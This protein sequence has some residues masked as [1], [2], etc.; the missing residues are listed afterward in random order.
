MFKLSL[1]TILM[2]SPA[3]AEKTP[4]MLDRIDRSRKEIHRVA[5]EQ[6]GDLNYIRMKIMAIDTDLK[7]LIKVT[8][9]IVG[10]CKSSKAIES[11]ESCYTRL[12]NADFTNVWKDAP[13][14]PLIR[15]CRPALTT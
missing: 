13:S 10:E 3:F 2:A 7:E 12:N 5:A 15:Y 11:L 4:A 1:I 6:L 14:W 9:D 8:A